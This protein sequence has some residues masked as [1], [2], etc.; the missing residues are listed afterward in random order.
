MSFEISGKSIRTSAIYSSSKVARPYICMSSFCQPRPLHRYYSSSLSLP[1]ASLQSRDGCE[2]LSASAFAEK[3]DFSENS[4]IS[5]KIRFFKKFSICLRNTTN[6]NKQDYTGTNS[7]NRK[8][9]NSKGFFLWLIILKMQ[10]KI[11]LPPIIQQYTHVLLQLS[12]LLK[13]F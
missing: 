1:V 9:S 13:A 11:W 5:W 6:T 2:A 10:K 7:R 8:S 3:S 4:W 12:Q